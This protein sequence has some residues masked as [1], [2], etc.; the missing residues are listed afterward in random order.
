MKLILYY[1]NHSPYSE[2]RF[3]LVSP[4]N[5]HFST[6]IIFFAS[7]II[8]FFSLFEVFYPSIYELKPSRTRDE[9]RARDRE[10]E[11]THAH[12]VKTNEAGGWPEITGH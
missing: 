10:R 3:F 4:Y 8:Y 12:I 2:H 5:E 9:R 7:L 6:K 11:S 1:I